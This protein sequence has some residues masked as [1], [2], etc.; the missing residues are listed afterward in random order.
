M[1]VHE[2][3]SNN[4]IMVS[5]KELLDLFSIVDEDG[6]GE[7]MLEEFKIFALSEEA[8]NSRFINLDF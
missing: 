3:F 2:M 5:K 8:N 4:G 6:S 7:L 1:E